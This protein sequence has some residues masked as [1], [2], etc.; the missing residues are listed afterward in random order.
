MNREQRR[1]A[2]KLFEE[3]CRRL[4]NPATNNIL[5]SAAEYFNLPLDW[6]K[7]RYIEHPDKGRLIEDM[8]WMVEMVKSGEYEFDDE[9]N[10]V[11]VNDDT[12][13]SK[14]I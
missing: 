3:K 10:F 9:H 11:K 6:I 4:I 7:Y 12:E 13:S 1:E 8:K 5:A 14:Q 2:S